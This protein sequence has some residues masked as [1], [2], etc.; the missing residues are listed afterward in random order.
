MLHAGYAA[1][2]IAAIVAQAVVCA[3]PRLAS[4]F[5]DNMV[6]QRDRPAPVCGWADP[7]EPIEV[8]I[9]GKSARGVT[10]ADGRW[11]AT[12]P[13]IPAGGP[14]DL[15]VR[16]KT[17]LTLHNVLVGEVWL[18]AGQSNMGFG[19]N[20]CL[21][22]AREEA[23]AN[24]PALRVFGV[25]EQFAQTPLDDVTGHWS[26]CTPSTAG[27]YSAVS[28]YFGRDLT[29]ALGVPVGLIVSAIGGTRAETWTAR[30][31]LAADPAYADQLAAW[32]DVSHDR[33]VQIGIDYRAF[34]NYRDHIWPQLEKE[35][36]DKGLPASERPVQPKLRLH[37]CPSAA[38]D[39]MI[40]PLLG[41]AIRGVVW[42]QGEDNV[43]RADQY[44]SLFPTLIRQW[45]RDWAEGDFPFAFVQLSNFGASPPQ[46]AESKWARLRECQRKALA[47]P[48]TGMA[49]SIDVGDANN[50]H[51][52]NKEPAGDRLAR[53]ALAKVYGRPDSAPSGPLE[54][55]V[56]R[57]ADSIV[58]HFANAGS[59]LIARGGDLKYFAVCGS[60]GKYVWANATIEGETVRVRAA[61]IP[62]PVS[63][64]YAWADDPSG[65]NLFNSDG[66]PASP[67][68]DSVGR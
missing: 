8:T 62:E 68:E 17:N 56:K 35:A 36:K 58:V 22:A 66:L 67:F 50:I 23:S 47:L 43:A 3:S 34:Q 49:V 29:R 54:T 46:P 40:A 10:G 4:V 18:C 2:L 39:G 52:P 11:R 5:G 37:D 38:F 59:G 13:P 53:W 7:G 28:Y 60:D 31:D 12:L 55:S 64:R 33:F 19:L 20:N 1:A 25:K 30:G 15:D 41:L 57:D 26:I 9:A 16:G 42:Y 24:Y 45:R 14:F 61:G 65:A 27:S 32:K 63:V 21:N 51:Y 48:N 44:A 6:I